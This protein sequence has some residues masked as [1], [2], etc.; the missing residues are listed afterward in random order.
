[1]KNLFLLVLLCSVE[2]VCSSAD[3]DVKAYSDNAADADVEVKDWGAYCTTTFPGLC[4]SQSYRDGITVYTFY[5][6]KQNFTEAEM[7]CRQRGRGGHLASVH[8][9]RINQ[10]L[11]CLTTHCNNVN[12]V[13][14]GGFELF[15]GTKF[16]WTDGSMWD[17]SNW[18]SNWPR[19]FNMACVEL[20]WGATGKWSDHSCYLKKAFVCEHQH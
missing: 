7:Y 11:T 12:R 5:R 20:N 15:R 1:M 3:T 19:Y 6:H 10:A 9:S 16:A 18:L 14:L 17:Y 2:L 13:W 4:E 8:N